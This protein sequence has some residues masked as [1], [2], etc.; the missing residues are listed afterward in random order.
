MKYAKWS[1]ELFD[2][3]IDAMEETNRPIE[4]HGGSFGTRE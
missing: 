1:N 3:A 2:I 4:I